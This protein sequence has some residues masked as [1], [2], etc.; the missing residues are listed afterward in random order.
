MQLASDSSSS[1]Y[2]AHVDTNSYGEFFFAT[3]SRPNEEKGQDFYTFYG[4]GFHEQRDRYY[5]DEWYF[6]TGSITSNEEVMSFDNFASLVQQRL[7]K[8][9][10]EYRRHKQS[11][12]GRLFEEIADLTDDD[13]AIA[14]MEDFPDFFGDYEGD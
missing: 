7:D 11:A 14:D 4:L 10:P 2:R 3:I 8:I 5:V 13:G 1:L 6:Y 12:R 9:S